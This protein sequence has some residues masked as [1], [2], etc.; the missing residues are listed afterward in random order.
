MVKTALVVSK[1]GRMKAT[2]DVW[3]G[4]TDGSNIEYKLS[5]DFQYSRNIKTRIASRGLG[6][7][8]EVKHIVGKSLNELSKCAIT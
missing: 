1:D 6:P 4:P 7:P 2:R 5:K 8:V 3:T